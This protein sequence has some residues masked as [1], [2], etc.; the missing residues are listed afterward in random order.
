[1]NASSHTHV[2]CYSGY[3][4]AQEPRSFVLGD[5]QRTIKDICR[6][7]REPTGPCFEVLADDGIMYLLRYDE[8]TDTWHVSIQCK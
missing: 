8:A 5:E 3:T 1:M 2:E 7:W 4:Y 6:R